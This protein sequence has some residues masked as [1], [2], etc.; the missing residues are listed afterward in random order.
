MKQRAGYVFRRQIPSDLLEIPAGYVKDPDRTP[1]AE[2]TDIADGV[3][4]TH[5][6]HNKHIPFIE[7]DDFTLAVYA[8]WSSAVTEK[9]LALVADRLEKK[10]LRYVGIT[11][12]HW[13]ATGGVRAFVARGVSIITTEDNVDYYRRMVAAD[14]SLSP[15]LQSEEQ[16]EPKFHVVRSKQALGDDERLIMIPVKGAPDADD[17][18]IYYLPQEQ[19]LISTAGFEPAYHGGQ[20]TAADA[21]LFLV[22]KVSDLGLEVRFVIHFNG[23][24]GTWD[25]VLESVRRRQL[26]EGRSSP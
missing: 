23:G 5:M 26:W 9:A 22:E 6:E 7:F 19:V 12:H 17:S 15:D 18:I 24:V 10:P 16:R 8:T 25:E 14:Y 20:T 2:V 21:T 13:D 1:E 3:Y 11:S 4:V